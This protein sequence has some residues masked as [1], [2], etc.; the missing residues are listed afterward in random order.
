[1]NAN[2]EVNAALSRL[3]Q[4]AYVASKIKQALQQRLTGDFVNQIAKKRGLIKGNGKETLSKK[5]ERKL[6]KELKRQLLVRITDFQA[7]V[8]LTHGAGVNVSS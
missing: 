8:I 3:N 4:A 7:F 6:V 1:M 2:N 5:Q